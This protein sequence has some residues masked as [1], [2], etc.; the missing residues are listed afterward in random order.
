MFECWKSNIKTSKGTGHTILKTFKVERG[1]TIELV[2]SQLKW[3]CE[4]VEISIDLG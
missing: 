1:W 4:E 2:R 3:P